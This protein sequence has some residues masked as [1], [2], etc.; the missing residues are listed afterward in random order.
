M[1]LCMQLLLSPTVVGVSI[2]SFVHNW[3][4][5]CNGFNVMCEWMLCGLL[6]SCHTW[7]SST[8]ELDQWWR[9]IWCKPIISSE[10]QDSRL[11]GACSRRAGTGDREHVWRYRLTGTA[12]NHRNH[13]LLSFTAVD[14]HLSSITATCWILTA[15]QYQLQYLQCPPEV[16]PC[17][18]PDPVVWVCAFSHFLPVGNTPH[19]CYLQKY[20]LHQSLWNTLDGDQ[21]TSPSFF[22]TNFLSSLTANT[23]TR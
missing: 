8:A 18:S 20:N 14:I 13:L 19:S 12:W 9:L 3:T 16:I 21:T 11:T 5:N 23:N 6:Y 10:K 1:K 22:P 4:Y 15:S 2:D 17:C 7:C